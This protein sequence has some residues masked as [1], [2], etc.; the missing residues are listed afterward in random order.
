MAKDILGG[1]GPEHHS[2][3]A[4]RAKS[5]GVK[6]A[7]DVHAYQKPL[8]PTSI[9]SPKSPG[10]HGS[11]HSS[12]SQGHHGGGESEGGSVGLHGTNQ[13]SGSQR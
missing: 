11:V 1:Y 7:G 2:P 9:N 12:G 3:Q 4:A 10:L 8:G 13:R 5:G 6:K